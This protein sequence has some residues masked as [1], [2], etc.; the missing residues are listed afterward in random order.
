ALYLQKFANGVVFNNNLI[1]TTCKGNAAVELDG[2]DD[3]IT[4]VTAIGNIIEVAEYVYGF[5]LTYTASRNLF[6]NN[7]FDA[8]LGVTLGGYY[9]SANSVSNLILSG[10]NG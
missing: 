10:E 6:W 9:L 7:F 1:W 8:T 5:K 4:G 2:I 3:A